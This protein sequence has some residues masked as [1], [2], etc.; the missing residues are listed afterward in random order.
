MKRSPASRTPRCHLPDFSATTCHSA[1]STSNTHNGAVP[2]TP[3]RFETLRYEA[4]IYYC[5]IYA[6]SS[7]FRRV[8]GPPH[9]SSIPRFP[10]PHPLK[11]PPLA[12]GRFDAL[13]PRL[14]ERLRVREGG[15]VGTLQGLEANDSPGGLGGAPLG[16]WRSGSR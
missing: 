10:A 11:E 2:W 9:R 13:A 15:V 14:L 8:S 7:I 12:D 16:D 1:V 3:R 5:T 4:N 6:K